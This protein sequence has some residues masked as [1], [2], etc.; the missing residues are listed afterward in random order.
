M[1]AFL[2]LILLL[3][4]C[5]S[6]DRAQLADGATTWYAL[7]H[8]YAEANPIY[9]GLSGPEILAAKLLVTQ[10]MKFTPPVIC[11]PGLYV[12]TG[13]GYSAALGNIGVM[14]GSGPAALP[15]AVALWLWRHQAWKDDAAATCADPCRW[16]DF[17]LEALL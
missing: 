1:R 9:G 14:A 2:L 15:L 8:G 13:V 5:A 11:E 17:R 7:S 10:A 12:L 3:A 4:G 6:A 16:V